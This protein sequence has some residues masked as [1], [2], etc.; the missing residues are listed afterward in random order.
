MHLLDMCIYN[1]SYL[2][3]TFEKGDYYMAAFN[4]DTTQFQSFTGI[5]H[6]FGEPPAKSIKW[7]LLGQRGGT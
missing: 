1:L 7:W 2:Y 6:L 3:T 4:I 5:Y